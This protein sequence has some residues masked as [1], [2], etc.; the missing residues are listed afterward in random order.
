MAISSNPLPGTSPR[1]IRPSGLEVPSPRTLRPRSVA[2]IIRSNIFTRF[3]ALLGSLCLVVL[4]AGNWRDAL[5]GGVLVANATIGIV[6]ELRAKQKL[7]RLALLTQPK[8]RVLRSGVQ[9]EVEASQLAAGDLIYVVAG[10][11]IPADGT[12]VASD[13]LEIDESLLSG[14]SAAVPKGIDS[15]VMSGS[16]VVA[17]SGAY[18]ATAVGP[19]AYAQRLA[20]EAKRFEPTRSQLRAGIDTILRYVG[21]AIVP[22][23]LLLLVNQ[24]SAGASGTTALLFS[25]GGVVGMVPEGLVLLASVAM[26]TGAMRLA[27]RKALV[28]ELT[29][30][31]TLARVDVLCLDKTGTLTT[32]KTQFRRLEVLTNHPDVAAALGALAATDPKP[33]ATLHAISSAFPAPQ[34]WHVSAVVPFSAV[35]K[36]SGASFSGGQTWV[37]GAPEVLLAGGAVHE[38]ALRLSDQFAGS[39]NRVLLLATSLAPLI[40]NDTPRNL[41]PIALVLLGEEIKE[42]AQRALRYFADQGVTVKVI[43]GDHVATASSVARCVDLANAE[44]GLDATTLPESAAELQDAM[45]RYTVFGRTSPQQKKAMVAALQAR[46][47]TVAMI[48]DGVN[49]VLALKQADIGIAMG[50]GAGAARTVAQLVLVDSQFASLPSIVREGRRIIGNVERLASLFVTKTV[51]AMLLAIAVGI[52]DLPFPFLPRHLTLVGAL[53]IGIPAFLLSMEP[54]GERVTGGFVARVLRFAGPAGGIAALL[55]FATYFTVLQYQYGNLENARSMAAI[56]LFCIATWALCLLSR[57]LDWFRTVSIA[58]MVG[59]FCTVL[60]V[61]SLRAFFALSLPPKRSVRKAMREPQASG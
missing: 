40:G 33:N 22:L 23:S 44:R 15:P 19:D 43:S 28:Q 61:P 4:I 12:I 59:G 7:A 58:V 25:A 3:N 30:T 52:A 11:Q 53:T 21:W 29:A 39:G 47:H 10:D 35:R 9:A 5:F 57:P 16:F 50:N 60:A 46:G 14:E 31:E 56:A 49:D 8:V 41:Q 54:G 24:L 45:E 34:G 1:D 37:L 55:T 27:A 17:G 20:A 48:G 2:D 42:T 13:G 38:H 36:W 26:A 51:Y 6:Q 18:R 32:G